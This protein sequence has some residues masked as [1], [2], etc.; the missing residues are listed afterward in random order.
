MTVKQGFT[1]K[2]VQI[3]NQSGIENGLVLVILDDVAD[4]ARRKVQSIGGQRVP[5]YDPDR[6]W[7]EL[8]ENYS[9]TS[10]FGARELEFIHDVGFEVREVLV[11]GDTIKC[12][13]VFAY[14]DV[15]ALAGGTDIT[16]MLGEKITSMMLWGIYE[17]LGAK[18]RGIGSSN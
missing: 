7:I 15:L 18:L 1:G 5:G 11:D 2:L 13:H 9:N 12:I 14:V 16:T 8:L 3:G 17:M 10:E 4:E 6:L